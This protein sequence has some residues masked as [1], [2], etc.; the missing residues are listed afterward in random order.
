MNETDQK[1]IKIYI[2]Y[3]DYLGVE[4]LASIISSLDE[5]YNALYPAYDREATFPLPLE[6]RLRISQCQIGNSILLELVDGFRLVWSVAGPALQVKGGF[7]I[8]ALMARLI[9]GFAKGFAEF[10][11]TWYEGTQAKLNAEKLRRELEKEGES[12]TPERGRTETHR[13]PEEVKKRASES[14]INF[15]IL[16]EYAPNINLVQINGR[17]IMTSGMSHQHE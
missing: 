2:Q 12:E 8:T 5:L 15:F 1:P 7:G 10:R 11:K 14:I 16:I 6:S 4:Q 9:M 13:F 3:R 17:T